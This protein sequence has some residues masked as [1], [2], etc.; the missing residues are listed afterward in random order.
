MKFALALSPK[1]TQFGPLF[2]S[3][4]LM[5]GIKKAAEYGYD[6]VEISVR[7]P[8][9]L[10]KK[11][12]KELT[13]TLGLEVVTIATGQSYIEDGLSLG[14]DDSDVIEKAIERLCSIV[15]FAAY[16]GA[17]GVTLGGIRGKDTVDENIIAKSVKRIADYAKKYGVKIFIEPINHFEVSSIH[18]TK[19]GVRFV[20]N[21]DMENVSLL[22]DTYHINIEDS[23]IGESVIDA[24]N[25]IGLVHFAD[26]NRLVPGS[27]CFNFSEMIHTLT[28]IGYKGYISVEAVPRPDSDTAAK[29]AISYLKTVIN[30]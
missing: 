3:G 12:I 2:F 11:A 20:D 14:A 23:S 6:G 8:E 30:S 28:A 16:V 15:D 27:G 19:D 26:N 18:T 1:K 17:K 10:D 29:K 5:T 13:E 9:E 4:D 25:R 21:V 7:N 24:G 22:L